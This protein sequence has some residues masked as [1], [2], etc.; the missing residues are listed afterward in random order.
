MYILAKF[1]VCVEFDYWLNSTDA[2]V[3][4]LWLMCNVCKAACG[5]GEPWHSQR[6][7]HGNGILQLANYILIT[8][9]SLDRGTYMHTSNCS[10]QSRIIPGNLAQF[11]YFAC[12]N[13]ILSCDDSPGCE[14]VIFLRS[15]GPILELCGYYQLYFE[16]G[17][18]DNEWIRQGDLRPKYAFLFHLFN[19]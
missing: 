12:G 15:W 7:L 1:W 11:T 10:V 3:L 2:R 18:W 17:S 14:P 16:V 8:S 4:F 9:C 6:S 19:Q 13:L 5:V